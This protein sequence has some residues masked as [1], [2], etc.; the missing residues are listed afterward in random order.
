MEQVLISS[1]DSLFS[2]VANYLPNIIG[3]LFILIIGYFVAK[4]LKTTAKTI[5]S[6][7]GVSKVIDSLDLN[8]HLIKVGITSSVSEL[9]A[10]L[11]YWVVFLTF[12]TAMFETLGLSIF[13]Q[14]LNSLIAYL[15]KVVGAAITVILSLMVGRFV[16]R[17]IDASLAQFN[18]NFGGVV[19]IIAESLVILFGAII[20]A[21]QLGFDVGVITANVTLLVGGVVAILVLSVGL[22]ARTVASNVLGGYYTRQMFKVG[23]KVT[24]AGHS[25]TVKAATGVAVTLTTANGDVIIPNN[26]VLKNGSLAKQ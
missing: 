13:V 22:G 14:T 21:N 26:V 15:P 5:L 23:D 25:G 16:H 4:F 3:A 24:L 9:I 2:T 6:W 10:G 7:T 20:A 11:V 19:A 18:I 8:K 1:A 17:L 12:L